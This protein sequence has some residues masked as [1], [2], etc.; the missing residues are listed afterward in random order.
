M[1]TGA[2][3]V[4]MGCSGFQCVLEDPR[5]LGYQVVF[6]ESGCPRMSECTSWVC[7]TSRPEYCGCQGFLAAQEFWVYPGFLEQSKC[8]NVMGIPVSCRALRP[9]GGTTRGF[10]MHLEFRCFSG[11][12]FSES[13]GNLGRSRSPGLWVK[14]VTCRGGSRE[15]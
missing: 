5:F 9:R 7:V 15:H 14:A 2:L 8:Q 12:E 6:K 3:L 4:E 13:L 1:G 11:S 10:K